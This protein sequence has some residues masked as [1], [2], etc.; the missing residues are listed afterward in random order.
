MNESPYAAPHAKLEA[1]SLSA[2]RWRAAL[3]AAA[4]SFLAVPVLVIL[5]TLVSGQAFPTFIV[6]P[7]FLGSLAASS[8][9]TS[10]FLE[11]AR[12]G[13][14]LHSVLAIIATTVLMVALAV[15]LASLTA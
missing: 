14:A 2:F 7:G 3:T 1:H 15:A 11:R 8:A 12:L 9:A 10:A 6:A 5:M 13:V 4:A